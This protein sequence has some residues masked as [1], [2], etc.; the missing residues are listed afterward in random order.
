MHTTETEK[1]EE[2]KI[3]KRLQYLKNTVVVDLVDVVELARV[4]LEREEFR[5]DRGRREGESRRGA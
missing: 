4:D 3:R 2:K 5:V 1:K